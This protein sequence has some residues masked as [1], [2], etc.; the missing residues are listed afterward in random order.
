MHLGRA[1]VVEPERLAA[2]Q[3]RPVRGVVGQ[4]AVGALH[5]RRVERHDVERV[6]QAQLLLRER[7]PCARLDQGVGGVEEQLSW[8]V[9]GF[10][11]DLDG[12]REVGRV[13]G[14]EPVVVGEPSLRIG[15]EDQLPG[16]HVIQAGC[17]LALLV[18][19]LGDARQ[20]GQQRGDAGN[21]TRVA[22]VDVRELVVGDGER[23]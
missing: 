9:A 17:S 16:P 19:H 23:P 22:D 3:H 8:V 21:V 20:L 15:D 12:A 6:A 2:Q 14:V 5:P 10:A 18:E 13:R 1:D 4:T 11:V 7:K